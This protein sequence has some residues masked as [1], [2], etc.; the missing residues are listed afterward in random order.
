[1]IEN[2]PIKE[3]MSTHVVT[4]NVNDPFSTVEEKMRLHHIRHLPV[5]D[6]H[7]KLVG[8]ITQTDLYRAVSPRKSEE[9]FVYDPAQLN[10]FILKFYMVP[11]P[12]SLGPESLV[13][14]AVEIM[15]THKFGAVPVVDPQKNIVGIVSQI[16]LLKYFAR[17]LHSE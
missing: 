14:E 2:I 6:H 4:V 8:M 9:G 1:M 3:V 13:S 7:G 15:I 10:S 17:H 12:L 16:D 5:T 11:E